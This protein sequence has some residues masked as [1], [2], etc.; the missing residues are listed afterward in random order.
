MLPESPQG[1]ST[2]AVRANALQRQMS[3]RL[4]LGISSWAAGRETWNAMTP[5]I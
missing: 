5:V 3:R 4:T 1:I 2:D